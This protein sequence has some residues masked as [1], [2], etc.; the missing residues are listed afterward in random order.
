MLYFL[1]KWEDM[2]IILQEESRLTPHENKPFRWTK[3]KDMTQDTVIKALPDNNMGVI[4]VVSFWDMG[5]LKEVSKSLLEVARVDRLDLLIL[6]EEDKP[7]SQMQG[8]RLRR[9]C[10]A[11]Q[12]PTQAELP[13]AGHGRPSLARC[14]CDILQTGQEKLFGC[15]LSNQE[16]SIPWRW[17]TAN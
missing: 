17:G 6:M 12:G 5:H 15:R 4:M 10:L 8:P 11:H 14:C 3:L 9:L 13:P 2:A 1:Y 16:A 7:C